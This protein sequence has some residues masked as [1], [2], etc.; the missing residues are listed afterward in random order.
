MGIYIAV[1]RAVRLL[2]VFLFIIGA[3]ITSIFLTDET[4][5]WLMRHLVEVASF[6]TFKHA[7]FHIWFAFLST[8]ETFIN[9]LQNL[10]LNLASKSELFG[11]FTDSARGQIE[12]D[13][14]DDL[15]KMTLHV[16][17][18]DRLGKL[19]TV[20]LVSTIVFDLDV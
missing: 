11:G 18:N 13:L 1:N 10:V 2:V 6:V 14:V 17:D 20:S 7:T 4:W 5:K 15:T 16:R 19:L 3:L 12:V 9:L 8:L